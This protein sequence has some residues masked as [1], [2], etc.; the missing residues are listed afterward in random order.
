MKPATVNRSLRDRVRITRRKEEAAKESL[1]TVQSRLI[2]AGYQSLFCHQQGDKNIFILWINLQTGDEV[3]SVSGRAPTIDNH[4]FQCTG[5][6]RLLPVI[7]QEEFF[8]S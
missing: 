7:D 5:I 8:A 1:N 6:Y 2:A 3:L 4:D